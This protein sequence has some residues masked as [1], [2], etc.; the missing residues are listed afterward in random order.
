MIGRIFTIAGKELRHVRRDPR[1]LMTIFAMPLIQ[2]LLF[3]YALNFDI[4]NINTAVLDYDHT[5]ASR[6]YIGSFTNS[7]YF[8]VTSY[9]KNPAAINKA[10]DSGAVKVVL[11]IPPGFSDRLAAGRTAGAQVLIDG[12]E[13]NTAVFAR[14]YATAISQQFSRNL[15]LSVMSGRGIDDAATLSPLEIRSRLWYNPSARSV[16]FILPGLIVV[17]MTNIAVVQTALAVVREK[18]QGTIEQL[19]VSPVK[20]YEL[21]I[22][23]ILPFIVMAMMDLVIVS[24]VG[25]FGFGVPLRG[26]LTLLLAGSLLFTIAALSMGL[27]VSVVSETMEAASQLSFFVSMLPAFILSGFIWPIENMPPALQFIS[28]LFPARYFMEIVR[29]LFLK[30]VGLDILW[31]DF[32]A[33]AIFAVV[34]IGLAAANLKERAG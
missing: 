14:N 28:R 3:S 26:S 34:M 7:G 30:G 11:T 19:I 22:G 31:P 13:P 10:I 15:V 16:V 20:S 27:L 32:L 24:A 17:I 12:T 5:S 6:R 33:L 8:K 9:L 21:M 23:K 25:I 18:A 29:G 4:K 2:L 1:V